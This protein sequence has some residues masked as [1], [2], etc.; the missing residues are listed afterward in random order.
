M[1]GWGLLGGQPTDRPSS[2]CHARAEEIPPVAMR[3]PKPW[4]PRLVWGGVQAVRVLRPPPEA[5]D[6]QE[7]FF[8]L[9]LPC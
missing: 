4:H 3:I 9:A 6:R 5:D 1:D 8:C 7:V 2:R